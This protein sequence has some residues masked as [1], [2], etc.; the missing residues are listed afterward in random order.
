METNLVPAICTAPGTFTSLLDGTV[1]SSTPTPPTSF[2][3]FGAYVNN[4]SGETQAQAFDRFESNIGAALQVK[5]VY[6]G[7]NGPAAAL[8]AMSAAGGF[9]TVPMCISINTSPITDITNGSHDAAYTTLFQACPTNIPTY[10]AT[11]HEH[12]AKIANGIF[13]VAQWQAAH[14]HVYDLAAAVGNG[15]LFATPIWTGFDFSARF[16]AQYPGIAGFADVVG[17][18][19]YSHGSTAQTLIEPLYNIVKAAAGSPRFAVCET[20]SKVR[21][22]TATTGAGATAQTAYAASCKWLDGKAEFVTWFNSDHTNLTP[23]FDFE[24]DDIPAAAADYGA[25]VTHA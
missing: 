15:K 20:A 17:V 22:T 14:K 23:P 24:L 11:W 9:G 21:T 1:L 18:D 10:F 7:A 8:S 2:T 6:D 25:L 3:L 16:A 19:P 4:H 12:D 13:T 5:R